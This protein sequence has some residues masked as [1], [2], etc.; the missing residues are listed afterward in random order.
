MKTINLDILNAEVKKAVQC[1]PGISF[2]PHFFISEKMQQEIPKDRRGKETSLVGC[3]NGSIGEAREAVC[4][5]LSKFFDNYYYSC[6]GH[7]LC[8]YEKNI[9]YICEAYNV[10]I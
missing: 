6:C 1:V 5:I 9:R 4:G 10:M 7:Y 8:V 3:F 2:A